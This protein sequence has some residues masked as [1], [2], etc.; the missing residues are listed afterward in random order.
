MLQLGFLKLLHGS[1]LR[2]KSNSL[3]FEF[4]SEAPYEIIS[5]PTMSKPDLDI[6]R[7]AEKEVDRLHNIGRFRR[8]LEYILNVTSLT[9]FELFHRVGEAVT[10]SSLPLDAYTNTLFGILS[11]ID[12]VNPAVLRDRMLFDRLATNNSGIIPKSLYI[13]D[14]RLKK[15]KVKLSEAY[16]AEK[17][18]NRSVAILYTEG[19]VIFCDY[20][21]K[22]A[23]TGEYDIRS[24]NFDFFGETF[25]DF[26]I[27]K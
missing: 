12:G 2:D 21:N 4:S 22:D 10:E 5:T 1:P 8:T 6:L 19:R 9:P 17:G 13:S 23:V 26:D 11:D 3:G 18:I 16:H 24:E 7:I 14:P 25:F 27:D 15:V 20:E